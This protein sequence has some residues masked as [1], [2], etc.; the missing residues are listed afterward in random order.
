MGG[1][2]GRALNQIAKHGHA[3]YGASMGTS[4]PVEVCIK[5]NASCPVRFIAFPRPGQSQSS[6]AKI[7][8]VKT[9]AARA[10][11]LLR[12]PWPV[13]RVSATG[14]RPGTKQRSQRFRSRSVCPCWR[15]PHN[16]GGERAACGASRRTDIADISTGSAQASPGRK[17]Q[18]VGPYK[19]KEKMR[20]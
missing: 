4:C 3:L 18:E 10:A 15:W 16:A 14:C 20:L 1:I 17:F 7:A 9:L 13:R 12:A 5:S 6:A 19:P 8:F 2:A 11:G